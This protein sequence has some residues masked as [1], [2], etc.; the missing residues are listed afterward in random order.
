MVAR[1]PARPT[2]LCFISAALVL[3]YAML[4]HGLGMSATSTDTAAI[5]AVLVSATLGSIVGFGFA[6]LCAA[7]LLP[8]MRD[9]VEVVT[10]LLLGSIAIQTLS[11]WT[12]RRSVT[13]GLSCPFWREAPWAFR[14]ASTSYG[15]YSQPIIA[16]ALFIL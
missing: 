10:V 2:L 11:V 3:P 15:T 5:A 8:L 12:L 4:Q 1:D 6:P 16:P 9:P 13:G 14:P 7:M